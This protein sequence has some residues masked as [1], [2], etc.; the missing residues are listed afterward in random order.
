ME[1]PEQYYFD[2]DQLLVSIVYFAVRLAEQPAF[3]QA[4]NAVSWQACDD[5]SNHR[6]W[7][8]FRVLVCYATMLNPNLS[9]ST[10]CAGAGL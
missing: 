2:R 6:A 3:V 8:A 5:T 4:C 10:C 9:C 7:P 1:R